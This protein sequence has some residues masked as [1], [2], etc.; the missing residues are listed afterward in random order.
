MTDTMRAPMTGRGPERVVAQVTVR[1][2]PGP[3]QV[4][5]RNRAVCRARSG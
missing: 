1:P 2:Q 4:L 5:I 3:G